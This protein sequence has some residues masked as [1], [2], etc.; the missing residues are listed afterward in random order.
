M[1]RYLYFALNFIKLTPYFAKIALV[2]AGISRD[3]Y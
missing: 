3:I 2:R 1:M